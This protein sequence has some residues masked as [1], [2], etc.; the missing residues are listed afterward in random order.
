MIL[1]RGGVIV[2]GTGAKPFTGDVAI[3]HNRIV[4]VGEKFPREHAEVIIDAKGGYVFPGFIDINTESD[5]YLTLFTEPAQKTFL[6][7]GVTTIIGGN[8]GTS[9]A[10]ILSGTL[11]PFK[12]W[13]STDKINIG[14]HSVKELLNIL[15]KQKL[16]VNFG[17]LVGY[18]TVRH[19]IAGDDSRDLTE[20]ELA[21]VQKLVESG[22]KDGAFGLSAGLGHVPG[23][24]VPYGE[25]AKILESVR[26][27]KGIFSIH[28]RNEKEK[29]FESMR[30]AIRFADETRVTTL[31]SHFRPLK[32]FDSE[33]NKALKAIEF[34]S[35][36]LQ[37]YFDTYPFD[38]AL[39]PI[40]GLLPEWARHSTLRE[41]L[42]HLSSHE[43]AKKIM[44]SFPAYSAKDIT[45][46]H[47]DSA[48]YAIHKTIG[49]FAESRGLTI[50]EG[51]IEL[52]KV[53]KLRAAV[54]VRS[55]HM[56]LAIQSM[57]SSRAI[58]ASHAP[59]FHDSEHYARLSS[60]F[61]TFIEIMEKTGI[62]KVESAIQ[63]ITSLPA[64]LLNIHDRGTIAVEK[65][66]DV[67]VMQN[68][69]ISHVIVNGT[70]AVE[71][72]TSLGT[73]KGTILEHE[74]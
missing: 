53:T 30:E 67:T 32:G 44:D 19:E 27:V 61:P 25:L 55:V 7:Q 37:L 24:F 17:T 48:P 41:M 71:D 22:L 5:H 70:L 35:K 62:M 40:S 8:C 64:K 43:T 3:K 50:S 2:D 42:F 45:I 34:A 60:T 74:S 12:K 59:S 11:E 20:K 1:I 57:A 28:L 31:V 72:G 58:I 47:A 26:E 69:K 14:W 51:I 6:L 73:L 33:F 36:R 15:R 4:A 49:E 68:G 39:V 52:M 54:L 38:T 65:K 10:P 13:T 9:L 63:K 23:K 16:G 18:D 56:D 21:V 66:A 29:L 46:I